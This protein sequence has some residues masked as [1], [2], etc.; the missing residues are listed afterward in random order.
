M[1]STFTFS[2][3]SS[4]SFFCSQMT[5]SIARR[6]KFG[7]WRKNDPNADGLYVPSPTTWT[8]PRVKK[9]STDRSAQM[10]HAMSETWKQNKNQKTL[11]EAPNQSRFTILP[12]TSKIGAKTTRTLM[13]QPEHNSQSKT[14]HQC[15]RNTQCYRKKVRKRFLKRKTNQGSPFWRQMTSWITSRVEVRQSTQRTTNQA[16]FLMFVGLYPRPKSPVG[17]TT[18]T[19]RPTHGFDHSAKTSEAQTWRLQVQRKLT[20]RLQ[21]KLPI[22]NS[23]D[24]RTR[25]CTKRK[26]KIPLDS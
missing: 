24:T 14:S 1:C 4:S 6:V 3:I 17:K 12:T 13:P 7:N 15:R 19:A 2:G 10:K 5:S 21:V 23:P 18:S 11:F 26:L 20:F 8:Q 16:G 25:V 22:S 9:K